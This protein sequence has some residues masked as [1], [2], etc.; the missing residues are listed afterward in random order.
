MI[1]YV[2]QRNTLNKYLRK[3]RLYITLPLF[4][5]ILSSSFPL[6]AQVFDIDQLEEMRALIEKERDETPALPIEGEPEIEIKES[7]ERRPSH[8]LMKWPS[9]QS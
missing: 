8:S 6:V 2:A 5:L 9:K 4:I 3:K 1:D 7:K